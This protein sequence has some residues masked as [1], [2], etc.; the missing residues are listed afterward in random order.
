MAN[1]IAI[2]NGGR[3]KENTVTVCW[4]TVNNIVRL[5]TWPCSQ[6][7]FEKYL[8]ENDHKLSEMDRVII[9]SRKNPQVIWAILDR[10]LGK[11][12]QQL[13]VEHRTITH[14]DILR[15]LEAAKNERAIETS[16]KKV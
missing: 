4:E 10:V 3:P 14:E 16:C 15:R 2:K 12:T 9:N 8:V 1:E 11:A 5:L 13:E 6:E 7:E